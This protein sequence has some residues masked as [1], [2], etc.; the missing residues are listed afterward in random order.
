MSELPELNDY[1]RSA[2]QEL[3]WAIEE[4][5][6][7]FLLILAHCNSVSLR[8]S[9]LQHLRELSSLEIT[10]VVL[11]PSTTTLYTSIQ[12]ALVKE[13]PQAVMVCGFESVSALQP[14]L[15]S[16]NNVREEF[17]NNFKFTL[18]WWVTDE[19]MQTLIRVAPD[20]QSW[21]TT[22][23]F[24][25]PTQDLIDI[26]KLTA[27]EVFAKVLEAG[28]GIFLDNA[29]LNLE[30]GSPR[31]TELESAQRELQSRDIRLETELE[32]ALEFV[33]GRGI[34]NSMEQS[35]P[36][37]ERSLA[38][39]EQTA[40][41]ERCGC[42]LYSLGLWWRTYAEKHRAEYKAACN[43]AKNYFQ[44]SIRVFEQANRADLAA[45]FINALG[46]TL[47]RLDKWAA[48][49]AVAQ[50][51]IALHE[52]YKYS[53][54]LAQA[55]G[56]L[57]EVEIANNAWEKAQQYAQTALDIMKGAAAAVSTLMSSEQSA[58]L[59]WER[60]YHQGWYLLSLA[61]AQE[62][63]GNIKE[64]LENLETARG[65]TK[66]QYDPELYIHILENL[67]NRYFKES[68]YLT[69]FHFKQEQRSIEQQFRFR[70]FIGAGRLQPKQEV[71]NPALSLVNQ[72]DPATQ[73]IAVSGRQQDINRL[74]ERIGR[75]DHKLTI[76]HGQ[77]GVGKSSLVQAGLIPALKKRV[78]DTRNVLPVLQQVYTDWVWELG[79][80][81]TKVLG[82]TQNPASVSINLDSTQAI[83]EFLQ[84]E[85]EL[86]ST[87]ITVL[88][89]D[90]FEEFFFIYK[91]PNQRKQFYEFIRACLEIPY[92]KVIL[93][94]REDYLHYLL[95]CNERLISLDVI[96]NNILDKK[97]LYYLGNFSIEDARSVIHSLT[98]N[99]QVYLE[100]TLIDELVRDLAS[101]LGEV[102]P[103]ELQVVGSQL[104]TEKIT[105]LEQYREHGPKEKLVG[106][107]LDEV[108]KDCGPENEQI[109][110]LILYLLTD[111]NNTR[112][113][114]TRADLE[115]E[116][117]VQLEK[118]DLVLEILVKSGLVLRV[119]ALP[120]NRYQLVHDYLVSFVRQQQSARLI[121]ELEKEREQRKLT[122]AKLNQALKQQLSEARRS[123]YT[124]AV[125]LVFLGVLGA[126]G[127]GIYIDTRLTNLSLESS[128]QNKEVERLVAAIKAGKELKKFWTFAIF[129][130]KLTVL[131][132]LTHAVYTVKE[133][134]RLEGHKGTIT[135]ITFSKDSQMIATAS[136]DKTAKVWNIQ[137]KELATLK[138]DG[139]KVTSVSFSAD[140]Q[141][142]ATGSEAGTVKVWRIKDDKNI[143]LFRTFFKGHTDVV[144]ST[145][146]SPDGKILVS[147]SKDKKVKLWSIKDG[148]ESQTL[149]HTDS[150]ISV[151]FSPDGKIIAAAG[152]DDTVNLWN[153][154]G[155]D[156]RT[157]NNYGA[158]N[159][160][161]GA[162]GKTLILINKDK[163]VKTYNT[164][165]L[166]LIKNI[167]FL[168][169]RSGQPTSA[170][171]SPD[172]QLI[173]W[174]WKKYYV[175]LFLRNND[176]NFFPVENL[177][178][179]ES[180]TS[181][182]FSPDSKFLAIAT[183]DN[184]IKLLSV[185]TQLKNLYY[186]PY[187][188]KL[189]RTTFSPDGKLIAAG[190]ADNNK[191]N[192]WRR[193][194]T[195][196]F[197][198]NPYKTLSADTSLLSFS[199][200]SKTLVTG[201]ADE[202]LKLWTF[203][204]GEIKTLKEFSSSVTSLAVS[205][206]GK[207]IT[208][209]ST[210]KTLRFWKSDGTLIKPLQNKHN[211]K[212]TNISFSP[213]SNI[214]ATFGNDNIVNLWKNDGTFIKTLPGHTESVTDVI[215]S[216]DS[217]MIATIGDDNLV[218][219][220]KSDG[221]SIKTLKGHTDRA[222]SISF[223]PNSNII[224]SVTRSE[225]KPE[226]SEIRLWDRKGKPIS[227]PIENYGIENIYFSHDSKIIA[228]INQDKT[229]KLWNTEGKL[230][231]TLK[232]HKDRI[233]DLIFS[234]DGK[235]IITASDDSTV[236]LWT[237]LDGGLRKTFGEHGDAVK[238]IDLSPDGKMIA[239]ASD[240]QTVRLLQS[241][242]LE[243][244][245]PRLNHRDGFDS[246]NFTPDGNIITYVSNFNFRLARYNYTVKLWNPEGKEIKS[247]QGNSYLEVKSSQKYINQKNSFSLIS[248]SKDTKTV[249][250]ASKEDAL[251]IWSIEGI[252]KPTI[253]G[254][255]DWINSVSFSDNGQTIA[256]ASDD[257]TVK[258][259]N[260]EGK[261]LNTI[262][263][264]KDK[265]H[266]VS[267]SRDGQMIASASEDKTVKLWSL[268]GKEKDSFDE[269]GAPVHSVSFSPDG[270]MIAS[271]GD[272]NTVKLWNLKDK[273]PK[274]FQGSSSGFDSLSFSPSGKML[275]L[276]DNSTSVN[277]YLTNSLWFKDP[278]T[279]Y[280]PYPLS[281]VSFSPDSKTI[282]V[283][284]NDK[285]LIWNFL[286]LDELLLRGCNMAQDY[287]TNNPNVKDSDR[288]LCD[289]IATQ[290]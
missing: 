128:T 210:D 90:Q 115:L 41:P 24:E 152:K 203:D 11:N 252:L 140:N 169:Y 42:V 134:N 25:V 114:K 205:P 217:Q 101:D 281:N 192:L 95:E 187:G 151:M 245:K 47:Q 260:L 129:E 86:N 171:R 194:D 282:A 290:K 213:N 158:I 223:S 135:S 178:D 184:T 286:D 209:A 136:E 126:A 58:R 54:R 197:P 273:K 142:L 137:G 177:R 38:L 231:Q 80:S 188:R 287:L 150:V 235:S 143:I 39:W 257:R 117:E 240:D 97:V 92:V 179:S 52:T 74:I 239:T 200:D 283:A 275:A 215:F 118:L 280:N 17:R 27:D 146:F 211:S 51:A 225:Y 148:K 99:T 175:E 67:R 62:R 166:T 216:E 60:S 40:N 182:T 125:L 70:A 18:V 250:F 161:F 63:L 66:P 96:S 180:T 2:L 181:L 112:P 253:K 106:R 220:W 65:E 202:I 185:N 163:T 94:L 162:K 21:A 193:D 168:G 219:L 91:E 43:Q 68:Q 263:G 267:F 249:A 15:A 4:P 214:L 212:V 199:P 22:V 266:S 132:D 165:N 29:A 243:E 23:N 157:I 288:T 262:K 87:F 107:F 7:Q 226:N 261:E 244:L 259:W 111:E 30:M 37:Y 34:S 102:R 272:D 78:I 172:G 130:T 10:E 75:H 110:K 156:Q 284:S 138:G 237:T 149:N 218:R 224:A 191:V 57:A 45:K 155:T 3:L 222:T 242:N 186:S 20:F 147:G 183:K 44:R 153:S 71:T 16:A 116:L 164:S 69:A 93:S 144:T 198:T 247:F 103:I 48:L 73:E 256:T 83:L 13:L 234:L 113:L 26:I 201:S 64:S 9:L 154:D 206:D 265:V 76:L 8:K 195:G 119:P 131:K 190:S 173:A 269:H 88:V 105:Q 189:K 227:K 176:S 28:S 79:Q 241:S 127:I 32:A 89:F 232:G 258:L 246:V 230:L 271:A 81:F 174:A 276:A 31:R 255:S 120:N 14:L 36:H 270:Q 33:L 121:A 46:E 49:E 98:K 289:G 109:A 204:S 85:S 279:L 72:Q 5:A 236:K 160:S 285:K 254:H 12:C 274:N 19:V 170:S 248:F 278:A 159:M 233:N 208:A 268:D 84:N 100:S 133:L 82:E 167:N 196:K 122:E 59:D 139:S 77:S 61:T 56:F 207:T 104:Q 35:R 50:K 264:H 123:T 1:N 108:V 141:M 277:L 145:S 228:S 55:Y 221:T 251:K 124:L 6:R 238:S 53:F 229:V